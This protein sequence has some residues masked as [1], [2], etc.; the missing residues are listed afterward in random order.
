M[1]AAGLVSSLFDDWRFDGDTVLVSLPLSL[2]KKACNC[3]K[4]V[5][6]RLS[7]PNISPDGDGV[8]E[9]LPLSSRISLFE[10]LHDTL[11]GEVGADDWLLSSL[12]LWGVGVLGRLF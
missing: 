8:L 12:D 3:L 2:S 4:G 11:S 7:C 5:F 6:V 1:L 10:D 9:P